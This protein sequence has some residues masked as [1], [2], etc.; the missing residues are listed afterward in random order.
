MS[1][2]NRPTLVTKACYVH[3]IEYNNASRRFLDSELECRGRPRPAAR[4]YT[5]TLA[6]KKLRCYGGQKGAKIFGWGHRLPLPPCRA[7]TYWSTGNGYIQQQAVGGS[8]YLN[9][10]PSVFD[11]LLNSYLIE[12]TFTLTVH[13]AHL[14]HTNIQVQRIS[15]N[16]GSHC[17]IIIF[18]YV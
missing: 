3:S 16:Y 5:A 9:R 4:R 17:G 7:A 11:P 12:S 2:V 1:D 10:Y 6:W 14:M 8:R 15:V 13:S 18:V